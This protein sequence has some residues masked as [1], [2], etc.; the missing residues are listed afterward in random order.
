[1]TAEPVATFGRGHDELRRRLDRTPDSGAGGFR[2]ARPPHSVDA[3]RAVLGAIL[4]SDR[5]HYTFVVEEALKPEDFYVRRHRPIFEAMLTL[6]ESGGQLDALSVVEQLK[7]ARQADRGGRTGDGRRAPRRGARGR[8][9][10]P[11]RGDRQA[12]LAPAPAARRV[13]PDPAERLR[14]RGRG[15]RHRGLRRAHDPRDP[16]GRRPAGVPPGQRRS[17]TTRSTRWDELSREG[18]S[19]TG[20]AS[21]F[22]DLDDDHR[23]LPARQPDHHR[24]APVDG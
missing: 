15:P 3:E 14:P 10:A 22:T 9:P 23:R 11:L 1:M 4:L 21:G 17:S 20:V 16:H 18:R 8:Q 24:R 2:R 5:A 7:A 13:V 12:D 6:F 19:L